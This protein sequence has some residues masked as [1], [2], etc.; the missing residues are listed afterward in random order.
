MTA[1]KNELTC[2]R[3]LTF[4]KEDLIVFGKTAYPTL[5]RVFD[6]IHRRDEVTLSLK[7][8]AAPSGLQ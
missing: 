4:G 7:Q 2:T 3:D 1:G 5:K 6:E 8:A